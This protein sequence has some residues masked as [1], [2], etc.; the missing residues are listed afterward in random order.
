MIQRPDE[1]AQGTPVGTAL[2][3]TLAGASIA[4]LAYEAVT[5]VGSVLRPLIA[6]PQA[7]QTDFHYYYEAAIRFSQS[8][9]RLYLPTDDVIAG[10]AYPPPAIV[11][12]LWLSNWS[13]GTALAA[14]TVASYLLLFVSMRQWMALLRRHGFEIDRSFTVAAA[15]IVFALGPTYMNA[16]F[17]QVNVFVLASAVA[18]VSLAPTSARVAALVLAAGIWL[19]VYPVVLA[20]IGLW[21]RKSWRALG[22]AAVA[23]V[24]IVVALLPV[25]PLDGYRNYFFEILPTR[26]DKTA[27][28]ITNQSLVAFL[29]RF[30]YPSA[31]FL[32]WTGEQA[33]IVSG[34]IRLL[35]LVFAAAVVIALTRRT[36]EGPRGRAMTAATVIALIAVIAPLGWGHTYVLALPLVVLQL[37]SMRRASPIV[38]F[39]IFVCVAALM[40]PAGRRLAFLEASPDWLLNII[41]S[42]YLLSTLL[43]AAI[44]AAPIGRTTESI[45]VTSA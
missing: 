1:S 2:L 21:D 17:G 16:I 15:L 11:P 43:L 39:T 12:F 14:L 45:G 23:L 13:L 19:K 8:S 42:R 26:L 40:I 20:A 27:I 34:V 35:N 32:N 33:V 24:G 25:V 4:L 31:Q 41:Y 30:R 36:A 44:P 22:W 29:E 10:F 7:L 18:F 3:W 37:A 6:N 5:L 9:A 28:H 38:A